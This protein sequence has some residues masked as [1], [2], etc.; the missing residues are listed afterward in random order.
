M[1][2]FEFVAALAFELP[3]LFW[4]RTQ[5]E[6]TA[7]AVFAGV[8]LLIGMWAWNLALAAEE[9]SISRRLNLTANGA[10]LEASLGTSETGVPPP[11]LCATE[12]EART[13][14]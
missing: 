5:D 6:T 7:A 10:A 9:E 13:H 11:T 4:A 2:S 1:N 3:L 14:F 12:A 8:A